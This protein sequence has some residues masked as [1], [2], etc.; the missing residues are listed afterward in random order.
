MSYG[1]GPAHRVDLYRGPGTTTAR[2]VLIHLHGGGFVS[3]GKSRESVVMLSQLA[4][5]GWLCL[6]ADYRLRADGQHPNPLVDTKRLI[7]WIR[8]NADEFGADPSKPKL[9]LVF[10]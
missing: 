4:A 6:S 3:G 10:G 7:A 2:P 8:E 9:R 5:H 1:P